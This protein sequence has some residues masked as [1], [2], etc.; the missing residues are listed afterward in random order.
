MDSFPVYLLQLDD[1]INVVFPDDRQDI[2]H[3]EFWE[4]TVSHVVAQFFKL[5]QAKLRD[6]PYSQRRARIVGATVYY[7]EEPDPAWL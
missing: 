2:G 5:P 1:K 3:T 6:L 7:G 4:A